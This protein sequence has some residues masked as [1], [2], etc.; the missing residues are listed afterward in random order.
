MIKLYDIMALSIN[1]EILIEPIIELITIK[2]YIYNKELY[3]IIHEVHFQTGHG[4]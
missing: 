4:V 3:Q 1:F 2:Y